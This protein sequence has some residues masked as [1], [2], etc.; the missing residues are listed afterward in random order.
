MS[1]PKEYLIGR[2]K[3]C[4]AKVKEMKDVCKKFDTDYNR[5]LL[6]F[7]EHK[8]STYQSELDRIEGLEYEREMGYSDK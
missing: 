4:K 2:V 3:T 8:V 6:V 5:R 7:W 1:N